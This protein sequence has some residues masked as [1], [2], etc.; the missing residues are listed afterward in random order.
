MATNF[1]LNK[2]RKNP[3]P[4]LSFLGRQECRTIGEAIVAMQ[5]IV[6]ANKARAAIR[7]A[8]GEGA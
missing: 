3:I 2:V 5:I 1:K 6:A 8:E 4:V 7:K